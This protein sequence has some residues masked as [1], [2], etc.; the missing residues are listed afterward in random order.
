MGHF[1][2]DADELHGYTV[3]VTTTANETV[4]GRWQQEQA[5]KILM[6]QVAVHTGPIGDEAQ[7]AFVKQC[8]LW[9][10]QPM[11]LVRLIERASV[12][13]VRLLGDIAKELRGW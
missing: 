6:Q 10:V 8:A 2:P 4:I 11:E 13:E 1:H 12:S 7:R 3:C 9:G 5:G